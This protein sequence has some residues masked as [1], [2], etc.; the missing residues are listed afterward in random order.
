MNGNA[1]VFG[2]FLVSNITGTCSHLCLF[3]QDIS[4]NLRETKSL[5]GTVKSTSKNCSEK[6]YWSKQLILIL[7]EA[8][9]NLLSP[10]YVYYYNAKYSQTSAFSLCFFCLFCVPSEWRKF[11]AD[12]VE[13][14]LVRA[15][16]LEKGDW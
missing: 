3:C 4:V 2:H 7:A 12:I 5:L 9:K 15:R 8:S 1:K 6:C 14:A 10:L 11:C 13:K 16:V